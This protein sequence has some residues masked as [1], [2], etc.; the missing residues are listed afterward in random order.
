MRNESAEKILNLIAI[1]LETGDNSLNGI[2][3]TI[4]ISRRSFYY[5]L[6]FLRAHGFIIFKSG[7]SYHIDHRSPF[8]ER[9]NKS[10]MFTNTELQTLHNVLDMFGN[11]NDVL[12]AFRQKL[13]AA[14]DF[15]E[16]ENV[17][18]VR[19]QNSVVK[20]LTTAMQH[21]KLARLINYSSPHSH[22]VRDRIVEP[23]LFMNNN[24]DVRCNE[25]S[26]SMNKTFKLARIED[27]EVL[28][29]NWIHERL[30]KKVFTDIFMFSGEKHL[31]V[32][33]RLGQLAHNLF[34]EEYPQAR[35]SIRPDDDS[36]NHWILEL[37]VCDYRGISRFVL[38]LY[39]DIEVLGSP[40]F[41]NYIDGKIKSMY[42]RNFLDI[43]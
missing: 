12:N 26:T 5:L 16:V 20:K 11:G 37:V 34:L 42:R 6:N 9:I 25:I 17:P 35:R 23:F 28:D 8:I 33:L 27:V 30:H 38:G 41:Q 18:D 31:N 10:L 43:K 4:G 1:L 14:Y 15:K 36:E 39:D 40:D 24:R 2:C 29:T 21:K 7:E 3:E 13:E 32:K 22:T 19:R